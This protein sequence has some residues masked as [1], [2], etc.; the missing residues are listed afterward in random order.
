MNKR[1]KTRTTNNLVTMVL[2]KLHTFPKIINITTIFELDDKFG[3]IDIEPRPK[4]SL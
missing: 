3:K 2:N 4:L 1:N